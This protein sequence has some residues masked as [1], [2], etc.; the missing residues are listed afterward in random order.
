MTTETDDAV[1][2][3]FR[4]D[5]MLEFHDEHSAGDNPW[6]AVLDGSKRIVVSD[7]E[8]SVFYVVAREEASFKAS[9]TID[10]LQVIDPESESLEEIG[11]YDDAGS[12]F[13]AALVHAGLVEEPAPSV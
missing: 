4:S 2:D 13:R 12:A 8:R 1:R 6:S 9:F 11:S 5:D 3:F 10:P 7:A